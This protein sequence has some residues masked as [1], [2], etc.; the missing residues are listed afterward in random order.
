[1]IKD[2]T[3]LYAQ[4]IAAKQKNRKQFAVLLDPDHLN[5]NNIGILAKEA[6]A[7]QIDYLFVGGSLVLCADMNEKIAQIKQL[8]HLPIVIFPGSLNQICP[9]ADAI[10]LLSLVSGRNPDLLIGQHVIAAPTLKKS[11]LEIL[12]TGYILIDGGAPTTVSYMSHTNPIPHDKS[13]I[14]VCTAMAAE[15]LGMKIIYLDA[16]SGAKNAISANM[17][18]AVS[19]QIKA[20]LIIGGGI[21]TP[22]EARIACQAG[23]DLIVV[24]NAL[25][26]NPNLMRHIAEA[27]HNSTN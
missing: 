5:N 17:I 2:H 6:V 14:A 18:Q 7:A 3:N 8:C 11:N 22:E 12:P 27:V 20:P 21:R 24:G 10:L 23:A 4:L 16:G 26:Q 1:M 25:E 9:N 13:P 15:M 19:S